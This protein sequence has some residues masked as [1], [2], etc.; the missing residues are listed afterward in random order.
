[1]VMWLMVIMIMII[2]KMYW[3]MWRYRGDAAGGGGCTHR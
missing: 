3:L 2:I 1:M